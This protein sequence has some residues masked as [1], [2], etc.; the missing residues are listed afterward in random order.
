[1]RQP[2]LISSPQLSWSSIT[3]ISIYVTRMIARSR[4]SSPC[5]TTEQQNL[6][7][8]ELLVLGT[9]EAN[10]EAQSAAII[11]TRGL[12]PSTPLV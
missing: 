8:Y 6:V 1:M 12:A 7:V 2:Y 9:L 4:S 3:G 11:V 5:G 10:G